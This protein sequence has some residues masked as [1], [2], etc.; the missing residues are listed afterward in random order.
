[1]TRATR[2]ITIAAPPEWGWPWLV[3]VGACRAG[4]YSDDLLDNLARPSATGIVGDRLHVAVGDRVP[5]SLFGPPTDRTA[6][7]V[8]EVDVP[9][10]LLWTKAGSSWA[11]RLTATDGGRTRDVRSSCPGSDSRCGVGIRGATVRA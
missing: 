4:W 9:Q 5:M 10:R 1:M 3:Q 7:R 11:W 8:A 2:A 6:F